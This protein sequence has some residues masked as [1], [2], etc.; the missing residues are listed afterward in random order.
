[1][2]PQTFEG[3]WEDVRAHDAELLGRNVRL[4]ILNT[5]VSRRPNEIMLAAMRKAEE[6]QCGMDPVSGSDA[7]SLS[8]EARAGAMYGDEFSE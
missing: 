1:M 4:I 2:L 7:V 6:I 3:R 5:E 8:R